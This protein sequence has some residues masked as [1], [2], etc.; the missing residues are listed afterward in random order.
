[1]LNLGEGLLQ[2]AE[3]VDI[4]HFVEMGPV[5]EDAE[6]DIALVEG[7][8]S[9]PGRG[10]AHPRGARAQQVPDR[11]RRLRHRRRHPGAAQPAPGR[12]VDARGLRQPRTH[13]H[14]GQGRRR[15]RRPRARWIC[16]LRGCPVN[17]PPAAGGDLARCC[18]ASRR[19]SLAT[20]VCVRMQAP[21]A[22][23]A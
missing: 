17:R 11:N 20:S 7:S 2:L 14:P 5:D 18:S 8:I 21:S 13:Q 16:E 23:F 9:T 12:R 6:A 22:W 19:R 10:R 4:R 3:Q 1:M 15:R